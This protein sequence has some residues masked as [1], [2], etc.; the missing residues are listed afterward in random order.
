MKKAAIKAGYFYYL[1]R[2]KPPDFSG[3]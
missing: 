1:E 2:K 3:G